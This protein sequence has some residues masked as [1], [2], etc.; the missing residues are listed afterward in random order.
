MADILLRASSCGE[1]TQED[2]LW[3]ETLIR[4]LRRAVEEDAIDISFSEKEGNLTFRCGEPLLRVVVHKGE[5]GFS[6]SGSIPDVDFF[7]E[8]T[9]RAGFCERLDAFWFTFS[10]RCSRQQRMWALKALSKI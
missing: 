6:V 7:T 8:G 9:I 1:L 4:E 5:A 10:S 2:A 3:L